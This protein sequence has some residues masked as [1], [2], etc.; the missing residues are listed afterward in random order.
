M[1]RLRG[2]RCIVSTVRRP[3][4]TGYWPDIS[5]VFRELGLAQMSV[6]S[7][8]HL[9]VQNQFLCA[10]AGT[11]SEAAVFKPAMI[12]FK[13]S[14]ADMRSREQL[15]A[16]H[17]SATFLGDCSRQVITAAL[18][19]LAQ[20]VGGK[21]S[22]IDVQ[23]KQWDLFGDW[24]RGKE[25]LNDVFNSFYSTEQRLGSLMFFSSFQETPEQ[26][27][28]YIYDRPQVRIGW[29]ANDLATC[30]D[31]AQLEHY[32]RKNPALKNLETQANTG[33]WPHVILP[34]TQTNTKILPAL[35]AALAEITRCGT[36]EI[37][38]ARLMPECGAGPLFSAEEYVTA[39]LA[40]YKD[41]RI[42]LRM[43]G[44]QLWVADRIDRDDSLASSLQSA[45]ASIAVLANGDMY[46]GE[47]SVGLDAW[48][49]GNVL[50][51]SDA[52]R[53]ERLDAIPEAF[54]SSTAPSQCRS[55]EWRYRCGGVDCS[56]SL[57]NE[58]QSGQ[59]AD[60]ESLF[61]LYCAPRKALFEEALWD[62]VANSVQAGN[63]RAR[64]LIECHETGIN[65]R[66]APLPANNQK[67]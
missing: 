8:E 48:R 28:E 49:I 57:L 66:P 39:L 10:L 50:E 5:V 31:L 38:P 43:V 16:A 64:E 37:I 52:L 19:A 55:C 42:P 7:L 34:A 23:F 27:W 9:D 30:S 33:L 26:L 51:E 15:R 59:P 25:S 32:R 13:W 62:S 58:R 44:P 11:A 45:G 24:Q 53:W 54:S 47:A 4:M 67:Q 61:Q 14:A 22:L 65:L 2:K 35:V 60:W 12:G 21:N 18:R 36:I 63:G 6:S 56:I 3:F 1:V 17:T 46:A 29:I 41:D 20:Q 40:I